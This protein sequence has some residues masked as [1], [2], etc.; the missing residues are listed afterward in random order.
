VCVCVDFDNDASIELIFSADGDQHFSVGFVVLM[1]LLVPHLQWIALVRKH[2]EVVVDDEVVFPA[3]KKFCK[4][5]D[6]ICYLFTLILIKF[7]A[8]HSIYCCLPT[9]DDH[10]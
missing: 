7:S 8:S 1:F 5:D 9:S 2:A 6:A 3:F 4:V 10:L